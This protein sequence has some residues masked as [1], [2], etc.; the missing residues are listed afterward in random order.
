[1]NFCFLHNL[2]IFYKSEIDFKKYRDFFHNKYNRDFVEDNN[3][4]FS[5][6]ITFLRIL[7][8]EIYEL[9]RENIENIILRELENLKDVN[10]NSNN[11]YLYAVNSRFKEEI[12]VKI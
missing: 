1:M 11:V 12:Q 6:H 8:P 4:A 10:I 3:F 2:I 7:K 5:P 9:H